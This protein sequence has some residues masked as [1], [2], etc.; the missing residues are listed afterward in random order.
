MAHGQFSVFP[1]A[2]EKET[3]ADNPQFTHWDKWYY[4]YFRMEEP[5]NVP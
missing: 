4:L 5:R 2:R 1:E 3:R